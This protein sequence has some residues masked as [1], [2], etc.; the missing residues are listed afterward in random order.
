MFGVG[1]KRK[2]TPVAQSYVGQSKT[3]RARE[4]VKE[5]SSE[6]YDNS[7]THA[8]RAH[9]NHRRKNNVNI[10]NGS[11]VN[12]HLKLSFLHWNVNGLS[13]KL[14]DNDFVSYV[15]SFD[16]V[17]LVETFMDKFEA[18][19]FS[20][21]EPGYL[22]AARFTKTGRPSG[23]VVFLVKNEFLSYVKRVKVE[24]INFG[25]FVISKSLFH[26][27]KDVLYVFSY[28]Q[29]EGS[30]YYVHFDCSNGVALLEDFLTDCLL[31]HS[32]VYILLCGDLNSRISNIS[33]EC[34]DFSDFFQFQHVS[35]P[36]SVNRRSEDMILNNYGKLLLNLCTA[37]NLSV[38]NGMCH[39]DLQGRYTYICDRGSS[40][41]DYFLMSGD[42]YNVL[43]DSCE[44]RVSD[45][46]ESDHMPVEFR[47]NFCEKSH[48]VLQCENSVTTEKYVWREENAN[49]YIDN[50]ASKECTDILT[51][52]KDL[53]NNDINEALNLFNKCIKDAADCMKS[54]IRVK[55][56]SKDQTWFDAECRLSRKN[57]RRL[58]RKFRR[59]LDDDDRHSFCIARREYKHLLKNKKK[60]FN[61]LLLNEIIAS[62]R[63][64]KQ[65]W[66]NVNKISL[67]K[68][69]PANNIDI[70]TWSEHFRM[71]LQKEV[72][73]DKFAHEEQEGE[74]GEHNYFN[75]PISK[76]E[77]VLAIRRIKSKKAAGP[78]NIIG[79]LLKYAQ[80][81][82]LILDF[83]VTFFNCLFDGGIYPESWT[84][85]IVLPLYKKGNVNDPNNYRGISLSDVSSKLYSTIINNRLREW[86]EENNIT[87]EF[88]AGFKRNY[89]TIDHM[90]TLMACI[91][92][93]F[94]L[95]RKLYVAFIDFEKA[96]DSVNRTILWPI[97]LK[98]GICGKM[99]KC[100]MSM[101]ECVRAKVRSGGKLTNYIQCTA[102]VK[103]GDVCSPLL[104]SLFINELT[105]EVIR[106]G[107]HGVQFTND[108]MELLILLLADDVV[109]M[110]ETVIGLQTQLN[111][112]IRA[113]TRLQL[114]VN[115][116]K[117]N[118][119]VFRKGGYLGVRERW[120][121]NGL[122]MPVVNIYKYLGIYFSTKL[123]FTA[124][125]K[126]IASR[127]KRALVYIMRK[128]SVLD[129]HS[130][131]LFL[132]I[133]DSQVQPIMQYGSEIWGLYDSASH[134][135]NVHLFAL[136]KFLGV[137]IKTPNDLVYGEVNRFPIYL[138]SAVRCIKYWLKLTQ[139]EQARLPKK[140]YNMLYILDARGK[141]NW[142]T[143]VK[144]K[145]YG[146]GFGFVWLQQGV[147]NVREFIS[148]FRLRLIDCRWQEWTS[149]IHESNRFD[150]YR[151]IGLV[152]CVPTY[153]SLEM[154]RHLKQ[155]MTRFR[156][157]IS[158][159]FTHHYRYRR[160][161]ESDLMCP[162]C[163][164]DEENE[165][166]FVLICPALNDLRVQLIPPKYYRCPS[167]FRLTLL[168][169]ATNE[170]LV[171]QL[172]MFLY[173]SFK[174]RSIVCS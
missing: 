77:V 65:F 145:L 70:G 139:M 6:G 67:K 83:F 49:I 17:C 82:D 74:R 46:I 158:D 8:E 135:E 9:I 79:E 41:D 124:A 86:V 92:K 75:R 16:F 159:I 45:R 106:H 61:R 147:G 44:L 25:A 121:Y 68:N 103:Q 133:F 157:G 66:T 108:V 50:I 18:T 102:G 161:T 170:T 90:Y 52:A 126:D 96:F 87:G 171:K 40:V 125:C 10:S 62:I 169:A 53:I 94:S 137:S 152:H 38:L 37:F 7:K 23:G 138:N 54:Q 91:Q 26:C 155:I 153:I 113:A 88:Q 101:Y 14:H 112:L 13:S 130:L 30:P 72:H 174:R 5:S 15:S 119:I 4:N 156:F 73:T 76:D 109:L 43:C 48:E 151:P 36:V 129:N 114:N 131:E 64:Q 19:C 115:M 117:S 123:S 51:V 118:I 140:A 32:D 141:S 120:S 3:E 89:S 34:Q 57:V 97:L 98:A 56:Q 31:I 27:D 107:K 35:H 163:K 71:L 2:M 172:A 63:N 146:L 148:T 100:I 81:N 55:N 165:L 132:K 21:H 95:N 168:L 93:Q 144:R 28:I 116:S 128:L 78:D 22:P 150:F 69:Q 127:G 59:T 11:N 164:D 173:K 33:H 122:R 134:C 80:G 142:V 29:P 84:E 167:Q 85:S 136:K 154:N 60:R 105:N 110:S 42:L 47:L 160:H 24:S 104:F 1:A 39:G 162:L 166:H 143:M 20:G 99:F 149:H 12:N 111:C 58:L